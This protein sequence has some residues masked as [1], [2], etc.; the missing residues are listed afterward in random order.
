MTR[1]SS[2]L[3]GDQATAVIRTLTEVEYKSY[4]ELDRSGL[5]PVVK[6]ELMNLIFISDDQS[7]LRL[8]RKTVVIHNAID[9]C[10]DLLKHGN[11][12]CFLESNMAN[13]ISFT[14][15]RGDKPIIK[16]CKELCY[17]KSAIGYTF[18][19][20]SP[21]MD[22]VTDTMIRLQMS[23]IRDKWHF[24]YIGKYTPKKTH[25]D[26][27]GEPNDH[28]D[29]LSLIYTIVYGYFIS[30]L[31]IFVQIIIYFLK[32]KFRSSFKNIIEIILVEI[33][34]ASPERSLTYNGI[35]YIVCIRKILCNKYLQ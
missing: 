33:L 32:N 22:R 13:I 6:N 15:M 14:N 18:H 24:D 8:K 25:S 3:Y 21:Y 11:I 1:Y 17:A 29:K 23:G 9:Y 31:A 7:F 12:S 2:N 26:I 35:H 4:E 34:V 5:T 10:Y 28:L 27:I 20:H 19:K 30:L 16:I